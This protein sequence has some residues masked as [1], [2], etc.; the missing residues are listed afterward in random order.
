LAFQLLS[1]RLLLQLLYIVACAEKDTGMIHIQE[2]IMTVE[3]EGMYYQN[4][5]NMTTVVSYKEIPNL[6]VKNIHLVMLEENPLAHKKVLERDN[7]LFLIMRLET[8]IT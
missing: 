4:Q 2:V 3:V 7:H 6:E 5:E 1:L 8:Q